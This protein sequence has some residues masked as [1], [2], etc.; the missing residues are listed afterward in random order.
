MVN[1]AKIS[2]ECL[3]KRKT[4]VLHGKMLLSAQLPYKMH[5]D[6]PQTFCFVPHLGLQRY[7]WSKLLDGVH[8]NVS[9]GQALSVK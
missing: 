9:H 7:L 8:L 4:N 1:I 2:Y 6:F 3:E 5:R